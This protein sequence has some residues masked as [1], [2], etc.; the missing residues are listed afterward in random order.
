MSNIITAKMYENSPKYPDCPNIIGQ[1]E[2]LI[3]CDAPMRNPLI[4]DNP[5]AAYT[6]E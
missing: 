5:Y 6:D 2:S 4:L 3:N 1:N